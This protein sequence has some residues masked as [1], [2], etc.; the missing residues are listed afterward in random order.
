MASSGWKGIFFSKTSSGKKKLLICLAFFCVQINAGP[1]AE[2]SGRY[3]GNIAS[4]SGGVVSNFDEYWNQ[5]TP[6]NFGKWG[7]VEGSQDR[8]SWNMLENSF[9]YAKERSFPFKQH[10]FVWGR[11]EPGWIGR[12]SESQQREQVEEWIKAYGDRFQGTEYIDVVNEPINTPASYR[13]ALGGEGETGFDWI[14][15]QEI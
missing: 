10:T 7:N 8:M 1:I 13:E 2:G 12:L 4:S 9:N 5:V 14:I 3:I 6:E 11:Q 15:P